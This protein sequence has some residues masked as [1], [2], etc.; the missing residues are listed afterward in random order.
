MINIVP[1]DE[2]RCMVRCAAQLVKGCNVNGDLAL[3]LLRLNAQLRFGAFAYEPMGN[4]I[5]FVHSILGGPNLDP[6]ELITTVSDVALIADE[7]DD[8]IIDKY[9][10]QT[11]RELLEESALDSMLATDP[12]GLDFPAKA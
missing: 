1:W 4:L 2:Q 10:G 6:E 11:M 7:Y 12:D 5:L 8:K 9:G 3:E